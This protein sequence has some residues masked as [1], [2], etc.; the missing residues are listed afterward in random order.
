MDRRCD[1]PRVTRQLPPR[2]QT[3]FTRL[4]GCYTLIPEADNLNPH[5]SRI[6]DLPDPHRHGIPGAAGYSRHRLPREL[7]I[8]GK[9]PD[10]STHRYAHIQEA[11]IV[12]SNGWSTVIV[13]QRICLSG[14]VLTRRHSH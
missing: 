11:E 13:G 5:K 9:Q 8:F 10:I 12:Y 14:G 7:C 1:L 6:P 4:R 2:K 3:D